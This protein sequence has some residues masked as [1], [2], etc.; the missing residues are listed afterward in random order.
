MTLLRDLVAEAIRGP[1]HAGEAPWSELSDDRRAGWLEDAD[2]VLRVFAGQT[3]SLELV[4]WQGKPHCLYLNDYRIAGDKPWGGGTTIQTWTVA[5]D[6]LLKAVAISPDMAR[7]LFG[8]YPGE[9]YH[10]GNA[11]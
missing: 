6:D 1:V 7:N 3:F 4:S 5:T 8:R 9:Q 2:R 11:G 10:K